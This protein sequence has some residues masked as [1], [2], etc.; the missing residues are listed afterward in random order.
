MT[1]ILFELLTEVAAT[2]SAEADLQTKLAETRKASLA[3]IDKASGIDDEAAL[4]RLA[5]LASQEA[6]CNRQL[7]V[8]QNRRRGLSARALSEA[9]LLRSNVT[10]LLKQARDKAVARLQSNLAHS[11]PEERDLA[12]AMKENLLHC[13]PKEIQKLNKQ[14]AGIG[15]MLYNR[16]A[17]TEAEFGQ[18]VLG[19]AE[20][21]F[22]LLEKK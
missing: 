18:Q 9:T 1:K 14:I 3:E 19:A 2:I 4:Q 15:S 5:V 16:N 8:C 22:A 13:T 11:H 20:R 17:Q 10:N 6:M 21:A 12:R 7:T